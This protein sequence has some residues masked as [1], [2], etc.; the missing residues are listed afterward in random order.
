MSIDKKKILQ[1]YKEGKIRDEASLKVFEMT[2]ETKERIDNVESLVKEK[3][4]R[5]EKDVVQALE[6]T[7]SEVN[8]SL[9]ETVKEIK[10]S[11]VSLDKVLNS[12]KGQ[13]GDKG[14]QGEK[15]LK[16]DKGDKGERGIQGITGLKGDRGEKGDKGDTPNVSV[17]AL[18]AS[19]IAQVELESKIPTIPAILEN[20]P[21][22]AEKIRDAL[23]LLT[24]D[25]RLDVTAIK[26]LEEKIEKNKFKD[27]M[28]DGGGLV[29][30]Q[31]KYT[32]YHG[33]GSNLTVSATQPSNPTLNDLWYDIS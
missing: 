33:G 26:G 29:G 21:M 23:E 15:G 30:G 19:K 24:G 2:E 7:K 4:N 28:P 11:E 1:A 20:I 27:R 14:E 16:G 9:K 8:Q 32:K 10:Q 5:L 6:K 25:E 22:E 31:F 12:V 13:K 17:I 18:E 3:V